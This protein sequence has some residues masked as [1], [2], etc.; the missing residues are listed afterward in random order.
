MKVNREIRAPKVRLISHTGE[1]VGVVSLQEALA[2]AEEQGLDL[3]EIVPGSTPPVCKVMNFGKFRYDQS[4]RE[5]ENKKAQHQ[6]KVKEV[7]LKPNID[8]HDLET[9]VRHARE[10][11]T[12]GNK[13]KVTCTFRGREMMHP[14][15][16]EKIMR[17]ICQDLEDISTPESP[18]KM[19]GRMLL[20]V[21]VPGAKKK[22]E[23]GKKEGAKQVNQIE[24]SG[25]E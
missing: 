4:K 8:I 6:I 2:M 7:K 25:D 3:V 12:E 18:L 17:Q 13:V 14:E 22:K 20:V 11:L 9:K 23:E 16:G 1:Q 5:K 10:F 21:L 19:M 24:S 15:L